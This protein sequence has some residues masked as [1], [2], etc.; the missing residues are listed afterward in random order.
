MALCLFSLLPVVEEGN[1][2]P[3]GLNFGR[4]RTKAIVEAA[5]G[6]VG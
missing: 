1:G 5:V 6:G 4:G 3:T 2:K